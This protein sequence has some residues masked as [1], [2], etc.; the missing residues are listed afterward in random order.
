MIMIFFLPGMC[1]AE[2]R[3]TSMRVDQP[4]TV[5]GK[6]SDSVWTKAKEIITHDNVADLDI[7]LKSVYTDDRI[8]F[9]VRYADPDESR[10]HKPWT[11]NKGEQMYEIGRERED[12]FVIK[13]ALQEDINDLSV[14][15]DRPYDAD[16]WFWKAHRTDPVG[17]ADDKIQR[18][19]SSKLEKS[20][21]IKSK[22]GK[23]M[24][25]QRK[26]DSGKSA[27]KSQLKIE[28]EGDKIPQFEHRPPSDSRADVKAK[29]LWDNNGWCVEFS[30]SL[31]TGQLDDIQLDT[32]KK[33]FF[34]V[35]R[36]E[37]AGRD[38]NPKLSQPL[39]GTGDVSEKLVLQFSR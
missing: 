38:P 36:Y 15:A 23:E 3:L 11:W 17:F 5:D 10:L 16:I 9:M 13:W 14:H 30:R 2:T 31:V 21:K 4:P 12:C 24:Y 37:I 7:I 6:D 22:S 27:Y 28:H 26:G 32:S 18:L 25:L 34:G 19:S 29:G 8:F 35:S 1:L 39:Y 20:K 33:Y